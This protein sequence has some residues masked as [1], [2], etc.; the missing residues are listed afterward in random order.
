[1]DSLMMTV[2]CN[3]STCQFYRKVSIRTKSE[4][5]SLIMHLAE[6]THGERL[7]RSGA[8]LFLQMC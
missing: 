5:Q 8:F 6:Q 1:M 4:V 7:S 3:S 2:E